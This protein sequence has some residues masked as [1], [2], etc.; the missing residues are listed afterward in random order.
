MPV[1]FASRF[2]VAQRWADP[3][4]ARL[5]PLIRRAV[6]AP[7]IRNFLDG[8]W[9]GAPLHPALTDVPSA[10]GRPRCCS[11]AVPS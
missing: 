4:A 1:T 2:A 5:Q 10:P 3:L 6:S 7:P 8:V 9:L 11:T